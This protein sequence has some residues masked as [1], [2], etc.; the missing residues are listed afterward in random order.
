MRKRGGAPK[1]RS[2]VAYKG[3]LIRYSFTEDLYWIEKDKALIAWE[4]SVTA[5]KKD[6]DFL[7]SEGTNP[8]RKNPASR[9]LYN[10]LAADMKID[11]NNIRKHGNVQEFSGYI[12]CAHTVADALKR[13]NPRFDKDRFLRAAGITAENVN[14]RRAR[15]NPP[16]VTFGNPRRRG[17]Q[18]MSENVVDIRYQHVDDGQY[19][20]HKFRKDQVA[21]YARAGT[22]EAVLVR[23]DGNPLVADY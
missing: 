2:D 20:H 10:A 23:V 12:S 18:L 19:Y 5:A 11:M 14:P 15:K 8:M 22:K 3:Y 17:T 4:P 6:I 16:L 13:D 1:D 21:L 7:T 9:K